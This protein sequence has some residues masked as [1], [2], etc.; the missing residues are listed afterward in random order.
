MGM[1]ATAQDRVVP[2]RSRV[3][4]WRR[5]VLVAVTAYAV[6][7]YLAAWFVLHPVTISVRLPAYLAKSKPADVTLHSS[8][9]TR[10]S[11]W[12]FAAP[13]AVAS[14]VLCHGAFENRMGVI[15]CVPHLLGARLNVLSFDFR[16]RGRSGGSQSTLGKRE[17]EDVLA[18]VQWVKVRPEAKALPIGGM[19]FSQGA[20]AVIMAAA[21]C[22]DLTAVVADSP[23]A[24]LD[25]AIDRH[26]RTFFGPF[27]GTLGWPF[28]TFA[29]RMAH[30]DP[31]TVR[32][33]D[34]ID[35]IAP[36]S[37]LLIHGGG[38][39]MIAPTTSR[40]LREIA[41]KN[42][43]LW[44]VPRARHTKARKRAPEE[45]WRRVLAFWEGALSAERVGAAPG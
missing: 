15:D 7:S 13:D 43:A 42:A 10:L 19:G 23:Y 45:Y 41:G 29:R 21:Q 4:L 33:Q 6:L 24:S 34:D 27:T 40:E 2:E 9:G 25:K 16:A 5:R 28:Y 12:W 8:D 26:L 17:T 3:W 22:D 11:G 31:S 14:I 1:K 35:R 38:D 44:I 20:A 39:S 18:A 32:P 36:R 37:V 30:F